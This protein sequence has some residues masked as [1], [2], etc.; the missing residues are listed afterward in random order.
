[1]IAFG[2]INHNTIINNTKYPFLNQYWKECYFTNNLFVNANWVGED[3]ENI[4]SGGNNYYREFTP[5]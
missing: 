4:I 5:L 1:M 2:F 3:R